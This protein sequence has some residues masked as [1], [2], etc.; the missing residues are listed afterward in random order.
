[1]ACRRVNAVN[2]ACRHVGLLIGSRVFDAT[3]EYSMAFYVTSGMSIV[4]CVS[5]LLA[6]PQ[7]REISDT[8]ATVPRTA[9]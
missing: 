8:V 2:D 1:M 9:T 4:A 5:L 7:T 3:G 6:R